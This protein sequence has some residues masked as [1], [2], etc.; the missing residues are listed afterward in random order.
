MSDAPCE[1]S[2]DVAGWVL[3]AL[4]A[5]E[6]ERF[7]AHLT[8]CPS[9]PAEV[10]RLAAVSEW[11]GDAAPPL[12]P[13]PELRERV[14]ASVRAEAGLVKAARAGPRSPPP[15]RSGRRS[16]ASAGLLVAGL[17]AALVAIVVLGAHH[18]SRPAP[19]QTVTGRVTPGGGLG[20]RALVRIGPHT[21]RLI[22]ARLAPPPAGRVYQAWV[23]LRGSLAIR[24]GA[25]FSVPRSGDRQVLLPSLHEVTEVIVTAEPPGGSATPTLPPVV[26]V[27]LTTHAGSSR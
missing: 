24:T 7:A 22:V 21:G 10:A 6:A 23:L 2:D 20:A 5:P 17:A 18:G 27:A 14:M 16:P 12:T 1:Y 9:C 3:G 25:L 13:P 26:L 11:L 4:S 19:A 15:S 8:A